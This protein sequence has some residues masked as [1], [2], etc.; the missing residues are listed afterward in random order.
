V[1]LKQPPP[2]KKERPAPRLVT[3]RRWLI[4]ALGVWLVVTIVPVVLLRWVDPPTS[5]FMLQRR[6]A[7]SD[8]NEKGFELRYQWVD[9]ERISPHL[10]HALVAAE[11]HR[12]TEH[13]GF[14][15]D[16]LSSAFEDRL[17]GKSKRGGSTLTQQVA[18]NLFLW[19]ARNFVRK[20]I[21]AYFTVLLEVFWSKRR[22][23]EVH[24]NIAEYGDGL[25]G[26][27]QAS[28]KYFGKPAAA[29]TPDEAARL[30][31][32]LP[33]PR[34]RKVNAPTER[35]RQRAGWIREQMERLSPEQVEGL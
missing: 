3:W 8:K 9:R 14:D 19:P 29:V 35:T 11:D 4:R 20:G 15:W 30:V 25:Y 1:T 23:L 10:V 7:A 26:V 17:E 13:H 32:V 34:T 16:A 28:R 22:I 27:E 33:A 21:E 6:L 12:F 2:A 24:L 5:A 31:V 18:K